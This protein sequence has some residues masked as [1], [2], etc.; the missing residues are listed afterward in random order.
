MGAA[1]RKTVWTFLKTLHINLVPDLARPPLALYPEKIITENDGC[2]PIF[3][4]ALLTISKTAAGKEKEKF[5]CFPHPFLSS[6]STFCV[7]NL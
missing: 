1:P 6:F 4:A 5:S 3:R 2:T 7:P